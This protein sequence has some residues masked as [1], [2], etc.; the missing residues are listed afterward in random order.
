MPTK[1]KRATYLSLMD[2]YMFTGC[3]EPRGKRD[4]PVP[5]EKIMTVVAHQVFRSSNFLK[6]ARCFNFHLKSPNF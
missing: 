5:R 2:Q 6:E 4:R 3:G 1:I